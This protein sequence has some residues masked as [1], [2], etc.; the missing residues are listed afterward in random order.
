VECTPQDEKEKADISTQTLNRNDSNTNTHSDSS[1]G[2]RG[3]DRV[4]EIQKNDRLIAS[5]RVEGT[6][7]YDREGNKLGRVRKMMIEKRSGTVRHVIVG[8]GGFMGMGEDSFP[9][10]WDALEYDEK[11][12]GYVSK[13]DKDRMRSGDAPRYGK[14]DE[15][16]WDEGYQRQI[17]AYYFPV[18]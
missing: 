9:L 2:Q 10:P 15:P 5:D 4:R 13:V 7:V 14:T 8:Y 12:D 6:E 11:R 18:A 16:E 1:T 3:Q 17:T